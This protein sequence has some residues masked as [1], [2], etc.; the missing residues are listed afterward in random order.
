MCD[1]FVCRRPHAIL[2]PYGARLPF[3]PNGEVFRLA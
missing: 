1:R 2:T 3:V